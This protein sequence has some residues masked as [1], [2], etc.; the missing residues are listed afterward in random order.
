MTT[1]RLAAEEGRSPATCVFHGYG[2]ARWSALLTHA[3]QTAFAKSLLFEDLRLH[4]A[5]Y[6]ESPS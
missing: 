6:G 5:G 2:I 4:T 1:A 3:A